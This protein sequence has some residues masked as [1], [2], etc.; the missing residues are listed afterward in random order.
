MTYRNATDKEQKREM[1]RLIESIKTDFETEVA[2]NDKRVLQLKKLNGEMFNLTQQT[3]LF[4]RTKKE[5]EDWNKRIQHLASSIQHLEKELEDIKSNKIYENS[6]E[7]RFE[8]PEVLNDEGDFMGFDVVIGN[9]PYFSVGKVDGLKN[10]GEQYHT[11]ITTGDIYMLFYERG[12]QILKKNGIMAFISSNK[13]MRSAYGEVLRRYFLDNTKIEIVIDFGGVKIFDEATVDTNIILFTNRH[14]ANDSFPAVYFKKSFVPENNISEYILK[15]AIK[16]NDQ[17][18]GRWNLDSNVLGSI[19]LKVEEHGTNL[20][21]WNIKINYG[22]KTGYNDAFF[23]DLK[24]KNSLISKDPN[25]KN[26]ITPLLRG[27]DVHKFYIDQ[28]E[29]YLINT[30]NGELVYEVD[31]LT[32]DKCRKRIKRV[33]VEK[34]YPVIYEYLQKFEDQLKKREDKGDHW[35]NNRNCAYKNLFEAKKLIYPETT[36]RRSEFYY[37]DEGYYVDKTCFIIT[38]NNLK[39]LNGVLYSKLIEYYL[40]SE[41]RT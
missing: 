30:Y 40:E 21:E 26:I 4:E 12:N 17:S 25:S 2:A 3:S 23:I 10:I 36:V 33:D 16:V 31:G 7:W 37:D 32:G 13:W 35:T 34:D 1:E 5:I 38:G 27:R 15:N 19:K 39:Y 14:S 20:D 8:F 28:K 22:I 9:P 18:Y 41:L 29:Q 24:T 6:F 11:F